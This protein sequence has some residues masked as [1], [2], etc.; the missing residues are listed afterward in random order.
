MAPQ[1]GGHRSELQN[2][3]LK[4]MLGSA[5]LVRFDLTVFNNILNCRIE[6]NCQRSWVRFYLGKIKILH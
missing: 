4:L 1:G 3:Y 6:N 2:S 5:V